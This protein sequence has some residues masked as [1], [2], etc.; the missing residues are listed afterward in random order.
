V[1]QL[2]ETIHA[3]FN[4]SEMKDLCFDLGLDYDE[5]PEGGT[6]DKARELIAYHQRRGRL[7]ELLDACRKQRPNLDW[8][9]M[10][11]PARNGRTDDGNLV[12]L[13]NET[14]QTL[15]QE[16]I[17]VLDQFEEYFMRFNRQ[18]RAAFFTRLA[19]L[20]HAA[21]V[22]VRFVLCLR[23]DWLAAISELEDEIPGL[24]R[25]RM[26]LLPLRREQAQAAITAPAA[27]SGIDYQPELVDRLLD[28]L[29]GK[30]EAAAEGY[31]AVMPPQL[32][33]VCNSLYEQAV[34]G[35]AK[36][37][38]AADY[39]ALGGAQGILSRYLEE[40]LR[41]FPGQERPMARAVLE[42]LVSAERTKK[43]ASGDELAL[44]LD[45][46]VVELK[47]VLEKLVRAHL[48]R[49]L[50][51]PIAPS[52]ELMHDYLVNEIEITPEVQMRKA[53]EE[54]IAQELKSARLLKTIISPERLRLI[55]D[56]RDQLRLSTEAQA[57]IDES[58]RQKAVEDEVQLRLIQADKL[59]F[60]N[61]LVAGIDG[62]I[63]SPIANIESNS[64][65]LGASVAEMEA[66]LASLP[67]HFSDLGFE[68]IREVLG[69]LAQDGRMAESLADIRDVS[70]ELKDAAR[71]MKRLI[72]A[73]SNFAQRDTALSGL[74][75]LHASLEAA[76]LL[77]EHQMIRHR[78]TTHLEMDEYLTAN[79]SPSQLVQLFMNVL[80]RCVEGLQGVDT[81]ASTTDGSR[82]RS[83]QAVTPRQITVTAHRSRQGNVITFAHNGQP[84]SDDEFT[85]AMP[86]AAK[87]EMD[88][89]QQRLGLSIAYQIVQ[90]H[91]GTIDVSEPDGAETRLTIKLP[92]A[93]QG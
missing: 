77:L 60:L 93:K 75:N 40:E 32:Q 38:T 4:K 51:H 58:L 33:L 69:Q 71:R 81:A 59:F 43:A 50:D 68:P 74:V 22:P 36:T 54:M 13:V 19:A 24:F 44:I 41:R 67:D 25:N 55:A 85:A 39:E 79:G 16:I 1:S 48:I 28:D 5:L 42:E 83:T 70:G 52:Y 6:R 35:K 34:A 47:P 7:A 78:I 62:E 17:L 53:V 72:E 66:Y 3:A 21:D 91:D 26:R 64:N 92:L 11:D 30:K 57:L 29:A 37:I 76:L 10:P 14:A 20:Y 31:D 27:Q 80:M 88:T 61:Q 46:P 89:S 23:E 18:T 65:F 12:N 49:P 84:F 9:E 73:L 63:S 87:G 82:P 2:R 56:W 8:P 90:R 45:T 15:E 86:L